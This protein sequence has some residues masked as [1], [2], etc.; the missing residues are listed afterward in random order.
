M[1]LSTGKALAMAADLPLVG[2]HHIEGHILANAL[3]AEMVLPAVV[4]VVS[5]GHTEVIH[6]PEVGQLRTAGRHPGRRRRGGL[7]QDRQAAG[8]PYPGGP[9]IDR[10]AKQGTP[11]R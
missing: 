9:H 8:L 5:G 2:I 1:G 7:R 6:M 10:M 4:L 3:T 11:G